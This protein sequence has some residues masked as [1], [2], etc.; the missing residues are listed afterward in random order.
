MH[1]DIRRYY[2]R[3]DA[4]LVCIVSLAAILSIAAVE[5]FPGGG[6]HVVVEADGRKVLELSLDKNVTTK[7]SGPLGETT[8][9]VENGTV[10]ITDSPCPHGYCKHM[11]Y[12]SHRGEILVCAPNHIIVSIRGG[13]D[14]DSFDGVTQ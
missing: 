3:G 7:V 10:R 12:I 6:K 1:L 9:C 14:N 11:G 5:F 4:I 13:R 8:V 2:T